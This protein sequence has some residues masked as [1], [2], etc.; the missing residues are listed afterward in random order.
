MSLE[1]QINN[2]YLH[3]QGYKTGVLIYMAA[4]TVVI[5][6][7]LKRGSGIAERSTGPRSV[8]LTKRASSTVMAH[9][10]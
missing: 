8:M 5:L 7:S 2:H 3:A 1:R 10:T 9:S 4:V 6:T